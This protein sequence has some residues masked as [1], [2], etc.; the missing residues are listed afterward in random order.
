M[1][2]YEISKTASSL[3]DLHP[4]E[5]PEPQPGPYD[6]LVRM[7]ATSLNYRDHAII[8]GNYRVHLDHDTIP[9]SDGAGE[10]VSV[11]PRVTRFKPGDRVVTTFFQ[12][13]IDG[14]PPKNRSALGAP[15]DGTLAEYVCLHEDGWV[16]MPP[17]L[18]FE[19]AATL[20]CAGATAWN[21]LM[22][23]GRAVKPGDTVLSLGTGGVSMFALQ[24]ATS[25][26]ARVIVTSSSDEKI[27]R[28]RKLG[29]SDGVNYKTH[30]DWEKEVQRLTG[31][32][33][34]DCVVENGGV[35]TLAKSYLCVGW[36]GKVCLIGVLAGPEG[37]N[38]PHDLMFK[39]ASL[40]GIGVGSRASLEQLI[41]AI[42]VNRIKPVI[43]R[44]FPF[45]DAAEAFR[46]Q[47]SQAYVGK[48]VIAI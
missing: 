25:A 1:K 34:V 24:F 21:A 48:I 29:A 10:V 14:L 35:G 19:E 7:R 43:D 15:M 12:I 31:G 47:A 5:R 38:N 8:T 40:H 28:A 26:G 32:N 9:C 39:S 16:A 27:A 6:L 46:Y 3:D 17:S 36:G 4:A 23:A 33:G 42:E 20:S 11:G 41:R 18:S 44:V 30:P 13:W 2:V 45:S 37:H 22:V